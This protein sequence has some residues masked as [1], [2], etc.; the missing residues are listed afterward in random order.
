MEARKVDKP[1][2]A[3]KKL[4]HAASRLTAQPLKFRVTLSELTAENLGSGA[5]KAF[6]SWIRGGKELASDHADVED[7]KCEWSCELS[8]VVTI[9]FQV[10]EGNLKATRKGERAVEMWGHDTPSDRERE[11]SSDVEPSFSSPTPAP[12]TYDGPSQPTRSR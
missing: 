6:F 8:Q 10:G 7:G 4:K 3:L 1:K 11:A 12:S 2:V 9:Y 5:K